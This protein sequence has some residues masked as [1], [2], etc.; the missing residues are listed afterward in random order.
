MLSQKVPQA[1]NT[2][3]YINGNIGLIFFFDI[4]CEPTRVATPLPYFIGE[5]LWVPRK[6]LINIS[7]IPLHVVTLHPLTDS[8]NSSETESAQHKSS[9][10]NSTT[11]KK[12]DPLPD[13]TQS[14]SKCIEEV[15][16]ADSPLCMPSC[17]KARLCSMGLS[18]EDVCAVLSDCLSSCAWILDVDLDFFSTGNPYRGIFSAVS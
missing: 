13:K 9:C 3:N 17:K 4:S 18:V 8:T 14:S 1:L 7:E 15:A 2:H 16:V 11:S 5:L 12:D 6:E 10:S